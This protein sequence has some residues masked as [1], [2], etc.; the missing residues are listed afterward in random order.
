MSS[1]NIQSKVDKPNKNGLRHG[2]NASWQ[3]ACDPS[4]PPSK[5]IANP[6]SVSRKKRGKIAAYSCIQTPH[7]LYQ[8][9]Y[10]PD[11][12]ITSGRNH[13][14][15]LPGSSLRETRTRLKCTSVFLPPLFCPCCSRRSVLDSHIS[16][17]PEVLMP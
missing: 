4:I 17:C 15:Q 13:L 9:P 11:I 16:W 7:L 10:S 14:P 2:S 1:R 6:P 8:L 5:P 12:D 3:R